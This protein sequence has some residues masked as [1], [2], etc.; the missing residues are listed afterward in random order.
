MSIIKFRRCIAAAL[1]CCLLLTGCGG[2]HAGKLKKN[3]YCNRDAGFRLET[4]EAFTVTDA[5][6]YDT[7]RFY[8]AAKKQ[9]E[10][11]DAAEGFVCEYAAKAS[12]CE[13][14]ICSEPNTHSDSENAFLN[15]ICNRLRNEET[16]FEVRG[17]EQLTRGKTEFKS[18]H[19]AA[20]AQQLHS[21]NLDAK[22]EEKA[23]EPEKSEERDTTQIYVYVTDAGENMVYLFLT[24]P[25]GEPGESQ[26]QM[27]LDSIHNIK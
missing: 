21:H 9:A 16:G 22:S 25:A 6:S 12:A 4:P 3:V 13:V 14:L 20:H 15:R 1:S 19:I 18:A 10:E 27:L 2:Y 8:E 5:G 7:L 24:Y 23:S 11:R 26:K 17:I